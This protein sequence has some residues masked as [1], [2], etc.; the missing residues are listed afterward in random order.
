MKILLTVLF[1]VIS[2]SAH[3]QGFIHLAAG[4]SYTHSFTSLPYVGVAHDAARA[5]AYWTFTNG[6]SYP[7]GTQ[8]LLEMFET[9]E[10]EPPIDSHLKPIF[11]YEVEQVH[12]LIGVFR[13]WADLQGAMRVTVVSGAVDLSR[14]RMT[15]FQSEFSLYEQV[16]SVPEPS[17]LL[18]LVLG[19]TAFCLFRKRTAGLTMRCSEPGHR[20]AVASERP[21]GPGR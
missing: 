5:F 20:V 19:V 13:G 9:S 18:L 14:V 8:V 17:S 6:T 3:A 2:I 21:R 1:V 15:V 11:S 7:V 16:V 12:G 4:Q 10:M